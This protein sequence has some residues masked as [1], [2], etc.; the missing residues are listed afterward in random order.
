[1][2]ALESI[3]CICPRKVSWTKAAGQF[4]APATKHSARV[5]SLGN[6]ASKEYVLA[7]AHRSGWVPSC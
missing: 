3:A 1:M 2:I 5:S 6:V 7:G 4:R